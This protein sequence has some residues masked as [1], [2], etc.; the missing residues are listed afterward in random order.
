MQHPCQ[1]SQNTTKAESSMGLQC[2][3]KTFYYYMSTK[4]SERKTGQVTAN[5]EKTKVLSVDA[6]WS[7]RLDVTEVT[8]NTN[9]S[10]TS[11]K[12]Y[13]KPTH[14]VTRWH[15]L[16]F[17]SQALRFQFLLKSGRFYLFHSPRMLLKTWV[18]P[19]WYLTASTWQADILSGWRKIC[20]SFG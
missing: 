17:F 7:R 15:F 1:G 5:T 3:M 8:S 10:A 19:L 14:R 11:L 18:D 9:N 2:H 20:I 12:I 13:M 4:E 16:H 6:V